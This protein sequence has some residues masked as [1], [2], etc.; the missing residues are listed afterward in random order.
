MANHWDALVRPITLGELIAQGYLVPFRVLAP[1]APDLSAVR[2]RRGADGEVDY[3][4]TDLAQTMSDPTLVADVVST[5][6]ARAEGR[7]TIVFAVDRGHAHVLRSQFEQAGVPT[8]YVDANTPRLERADLARGLSSGDIKVLVN[9]DVL[10]AGFDCPAVSC[11]V[12]A[13][14]T[15]S[16]IRYVQSAGRGLRPSPET[17]K[18]DLL[19]IDHSDTTASLGFITDINHDGLDGGTERRSPAHQKPRA[20]LAKK[21]PSCSF[22]KPARVNACPVCG[23]RRRFATISVVLRASLSSSTGGGRSKK[24]SV[25]FGWLTDDELLGQLRHYGAERQYKPGWASAKF[26]TLRGKWPP[27]YV[28]PAVRATAGHGAAQLD[29]AGDHPMGKIPRG[30]QCPSI[31]R[32]GARRV[33]DRF[34]AT[35]RIYRALLCLEAIIPSRKM[36][37]DGDRLHLQRLE[38]WESS[39]YRRGSWRTGWIFV[40]LRRRRRFESS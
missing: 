3:V 23:L 7:P 35:P 19:I 24:S 31:T 9:I 20:A 32:P 16:E 1:S 5:W 15:C 39:R 18:T 6:C 11:I 33:A 21:C 36:R 8:G 4:E 22:L 14:P 30:A 37:M 27:R 2:S 40:R 38:Q 26:K 12:L 29:L 10:T 25:K 13:R 17:G 28:A 34:C